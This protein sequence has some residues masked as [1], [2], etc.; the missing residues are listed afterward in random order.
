MQLLINFVRKSGV[1]T[2]AVLILLFVALVNSLILG[3]TQLC[4][5]RAV[6]GYPCPGCGLSHA[7]IYLFKGQLAESLRWHPLLVPLVITLIV[8]SIPVGVWKFS[9]KCKNFIWW[10]ILLLVAF[11]TLFI[12]R[13]IMFYPQSPDDG[14]MY[15]DKANYYH[16]ISNMIESL[17]K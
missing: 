15:Y 11:M 8:E 14:P 16:K 1:Y 4:A 7:G 3:S 10:K 12:S 13:L 9:D 5:W 2:L 6:I 17:K